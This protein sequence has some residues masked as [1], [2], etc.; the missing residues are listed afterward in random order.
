MNNFI[1]VARIAKD[2]ESFKTKSD[3]AGVRLLL[4]IPRPYSKSRTEGS[5]DADFMNA[6]AYSAT[7]EFILRNATKGSRLHVSGCVRADRYVKDGQTRYSVPY[8]LID[9][10]NLIDFKKNDAQQGTPTNNTSTSSNSDDGWGE[11]I[12]F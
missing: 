3:K 10:V 11:D 5:Q 12:P 6:V 7:A 2:P 1:T 9:Q 8:I 4:A